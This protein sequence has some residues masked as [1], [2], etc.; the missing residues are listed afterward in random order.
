[1]SRHRCILLAE[2]D[3]V[4]QEVTLE[5]LREVLGMDGMA[6]ARAIRPRSHADPRH[7]GQRLRGRPPSLPRERH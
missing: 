4:N 2:D 3:R 5:L 1:M 7:D 6:A